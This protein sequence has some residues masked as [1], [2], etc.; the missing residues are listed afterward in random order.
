MDLTHYNQVC[1]APSESGVENPQEGC[2]QRLRE[3]ERASKG[4]GAGQLIAGSRRRLDEMQTSKLDFCLSC[5]LV[6][7]HDVFV[8]LVVVLE[9]SSS[10][11]AA[12]KQPDGGS[13][14]SIYLVN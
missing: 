8:V 9:S 10:E 2:S 5:S 12:D 1:I 11:A 6:T 13:C 7:K 14:L 3:R 4:C